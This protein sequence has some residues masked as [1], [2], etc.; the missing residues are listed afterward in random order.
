MR[1]G[2]A[3]ASASIAAVL[4][5]SPAKA[6]GPGPAL[7]TPT[8]ALA[9]ALTC[10]GNL[11]ASAKTPLLLVH[12]TAATPAEDWG[13][14]IQP[15]LVN[16][17]YPVCAVT[18]PKRAMDDVQGNVEYVVHALRYMAAE[19]GRKVSAIGH[20]QGAFLITYALRFWPDL[21]DTV[22][23]VVGY[24]G[25]YTYGTDFSKVFCA[26]ACPRAFQQFRPGSKLLAAL[27][28]APLPS[29]PSYTTFATRYDEIVIPQPKA[30]AIDAVGARAYTLQDLCPLA[31]SEHI[32]IPDE[33][34]L[35]A[36]TVDALSNA[37]PADVA[38][39]GR[40]PCGNL[41]PTGAVLSGAA[42]TFATGAVTVG[43]AVLASEEPPLRCY[44]TGSCP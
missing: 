6:A 15:R 40:V 2:L 30:G 35:F 44:L 23:D 36:L 3:L 39:L 32:L 9:A 38:R 41:N 37:G 19:S 5:A 1:L 21:A 16:S 8:S 10:K 26:A 27:A 33:R 22:D 25:V 18:I 34:A 11:A 28:E 13:W 4:V 31:V 17:G 43:S 14:N 29:E 12:G 7:E 20:S 42:V 24:A